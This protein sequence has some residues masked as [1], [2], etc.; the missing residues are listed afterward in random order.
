MFSPSRLHPLP[1]ELEPV[2]T[3]ARQMLRLDLLAAQ[4]SESHYLLDAQSKRVILEP[5]VLVTFLLLAWLEVP[6][7]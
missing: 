6:A 2:A 5:A 3:A 7:C 4:P 1:V